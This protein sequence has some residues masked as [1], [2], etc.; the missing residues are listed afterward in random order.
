[1]QRLRGE[2]MAAGNEAARGVEGGCFFC[3]GA[4]HPAT[5]CEYSARVLACG[6]CTRSF[7]KWMR[8]WTNRAYKGRPSFYDAAGR[9][10][11]K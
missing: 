7:W 10:R 5:G 8:E 4:A 3:G 6:P 11:V 1:M 2:S 9:W